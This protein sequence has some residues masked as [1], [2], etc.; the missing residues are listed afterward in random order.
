MLKVEKK[1]HGSVAVEAYKYDQESSLRKLYLAIIMHEYPFNIVEHEYFRDFI[2]SLRPS[3][4][5]KNRNTVKNEIVAMFE[6]EKDKLYEYFKTINWHFSTTMDM[7]TSN[8]NKGYMCVTVHW[9]D[10]EWIIQKRIIKFMHVEGRHTGLNMSGEFIACILRW[11]IEK[12]MFSLT[13]DNASSNEVCV[14][15]VISKLKEYSPLVCD[16]E[17]FHVRCANH[18]LN[19]VARDGLDQI[20]NAFWGVKAFVLAVKSSPQLEEE[21]YKCASECGLSTEK[22][23]RLDVQTRWNSTYHMLSDALYYKKAFDRLHEIDKKKFDKFAPTADDWDKA[24]TLCRCL[25]KFDDLTTLLSG[26]QYPIA[27]LFHKGFCEIKALISG[28][29]KSSDTTIKKMAGSMQTKFDKYWRKSNLAL[30]VAFFLDPRYK[31]SG[32][33]H[34]MRKVHGEL[35]YRCKVEE[36]IIV[37]KQMYQAYQNEYAQSTDGPSCTTTS[38]EGNTDLMVEDEDDYFLSQQGTHGSNDGDTDLD[39]YMAEARVRLS[40]VAFENFDILSW[41]KTHQDVYPVLSMLARDVL[42]IQVSTVAS[43]AAFSA[44]GRVIDP[45]RSRLDPYVVEALICTK[46]WVAASRKND[47]K[48]GDRLGSIVNDLE[49]VET[50]IANMSLEEQLDEKVRLCP[51]YHSYS[52]WKRLAFMIINALY[53]I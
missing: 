29:R 50:L 10:D 27:N 19:L 52:F 45:F 44:G 38:Q 14:K 9:I 7:W 34:Y 11:F 8:Q 22:G 28:W 35:L 21:F 49:V 31:R 51:L 20:S 43:E 42:A 23:L 3:F 12:K 39:K 25:K 24:L 32:I 4:P 18:V 16:G 30:A 17:F 15:H 53:M 5:L 13:L 48:R 2:K 37:V 26:N 40:K 6:T 41:W 36:L 46:D 47:N 1:E 33:E